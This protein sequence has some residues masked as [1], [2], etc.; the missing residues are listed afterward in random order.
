MAKVRKRTWANAKGE[1]VAWVTDYFDQNGKRHIKTFERKRDAD[2]W[3]VQTRGEVARGVH[4]PES[5]SITVAEAAAL[6]LERGEREELEQSTMR[7]YRRH[8]DLCLVP[9]I[10]GERLARLSTP[11]IEMFRDRLLKEV[12]RITARR[13]LTSLK[14]ILKEAQRRGLVAHNA[15]QPVRIETK[16]REQGKLD[17]GRNVPSKAEVQAILTHAG[18][19]WRPILITAVFTGL[20]ASELRGLAWDV[21]DFE[22][23]TIAVRQRA[24]LWGEIGP[25]KSA[26]GERAVPLAPIVVNTLKEWRLACPKG[27]ANLVFPN[28]AGNIEFH[29]NL[30]Q[31][32][33]YP[34]QLAAGVVDGRVAPIL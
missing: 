5:T 33:F 17:I 1:H 31:R 6:W 29:Q 18:A 2:A 30:A 9:R 27:P 22:R 4:T 26:A 24:N 7:E 15:A 14:G 10:G 21:V 11:A 32:G 8:V 34:A 12:P 20:R 23:K 3:L 25:P 19:R 28:G 13:V 16:K